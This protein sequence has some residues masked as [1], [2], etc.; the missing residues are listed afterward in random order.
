MLAASGF[1]TYVGLRGALTAHR[2]AIARRLPAHA[3]PAAMSAQELER[4]A[5]SLLGLVAGGVL[6]AE[7]PELLFIAAAVL[8][9]VLAVPTAVILRRSR[10]FDDLGDADGQPHERARPRDLLAV[11][12]CPGAREV[13]AA[14]AL[15]VLAYVALPTFFILYA[16]E[17]LG[18]GPP[19]SSFAL[20]G[21]ALLAGAGTLVAGRLD[22]QRVRG[23]LIAGAAALGAGL[24][25]ASA[26]D[27]LAAVAVPFGVAAFG[28]GLVNTLGFPYFSRFL[29]GDAAGRFSGVFFSVRAVAAAVALP[30]AGAL[31]DMTG[32]YRVILLQGA[33]A[34]LALVPLLRTHAPPQEEHEGR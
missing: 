27:D 16:T 19:A 21:V 24:L 6:V 3:R 18:V 31:A 12:R 10:A 13:L 7:S 30:L 28:F 1:V 33:A 22:P 20:A 29:D 26:F 9:P 11:A 14:Q 5:G 2:A 25:V 34:L 32:S 23:G 15:W 17:V 8:L 4:S